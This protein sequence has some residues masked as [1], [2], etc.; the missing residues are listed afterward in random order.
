MHDCFKRRCACIVSCSRTTA[1]SRAEPLDLLDA[2]IDRLLSKRLHREADQC[3]DAPPNRAAE[4]R[5]AN[6][7]MRAAGRRIDGAW[8]RAARGPHRTENRSCAAADDDADQH[9]MSA[10]V[11]G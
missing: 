2:A 9:G 3:S 11:C 4:K 10:G 7:R 1:L 6:P 5:S 8:L